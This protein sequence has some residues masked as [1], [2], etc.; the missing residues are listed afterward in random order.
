V[1]NL[2]KY[3]S[4][5]MKLL[6]NSSKEF[7]D[8]FEIMHD[9]GNR[10]FSE[11]TDGYTIKTTTY[12][13][14]KEYSLKMGLY[15]KEKLDNFKSN[16][17]VG[18]LMDNSL[19]WVATFWG[20]LMAGYKPVLLN[21]RFNKQL[22]ENVIQM[23]NISIIITDDVYDFNVDYIRP[24]IEEIKSLKVKEKYEF[25]WANEI[26]LTT[27]ATSLDV[28]VC[29]YQGY[30]ISEQIMNTKKIVKE[31]PMVK[32]HYKGRLKILAFLPF[33]HI[34]GLVATYFW[35]SFFGRTFVFLKDY[36]TQTILKTIKK[37]AIKTIN[38]FKK[39]E[40]SL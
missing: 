15:L 9:Q 3:I 30:A 1:E 14:I 2:N 5:K 31:N 35:F 17:F 16:E 24:T 39:C 20:I 19:L 7:K 23:T 18:L 25:N 11:I 6:N 33:Y 26:A 12:D 10:I 36:S 29:I 8:I 21:K 4:T 32:K 27:S 34:F 28:K 38:S 13:E 40:K 37:V 22:N